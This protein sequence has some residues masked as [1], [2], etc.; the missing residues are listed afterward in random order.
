MQQ[1]VNRLKS[2]MADAT[3]TPSA[4]PVV[5]KPHPHWDSDDA[6]ALRIFL[7]SP[8]GIRTLAWLKYWRPELLDGEHKNKT[9]VRSGQVKGY[10]EAV[11]NM[12]S[13]TK[14]NPVP[15]DGLTS[16]PEY[17]SLDDDTKWSDA[18]SKRE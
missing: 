11:E 13:L 2:D 14:E 12:H 6:R 18:E 10:D 17:P 9:L 5:P 7:E 15:D 4:I 3:S 1:P 16:S 8:V